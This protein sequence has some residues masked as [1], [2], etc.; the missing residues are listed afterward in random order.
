[1]YV[2]VFMYVCVYAA[3]VTQTCV[4]NVMYLCIH[5]HGCPHVCHVS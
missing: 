5:I 2:C 4:V 3:Q 1:M